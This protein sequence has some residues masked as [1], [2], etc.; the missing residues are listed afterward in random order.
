M[1]FLV[2]KKK[3]KTRQASWFSLSRKVYSRDKSSE[4]GSDPLLRDI[5]ATLI[6]WANWHDAKHAL[7]GQR[8]ILRRGQLTTSAA[9]LGDYCR[10]TRK[11]VRAR[12]D[13]LVLTERIKID[14]KPG[15][16]AILTILQFDKHQ[17]LTEK[18]PVDRAVQKT[19]FN[20]GHEKA[21]EGP[22]KGQ[23]DDF[24]LVPQV[25]DDTG[26]IIG[27]DLNSSCGQGQTKAKER[28]SQGHNEYNSTSIQPTS[29]YSAP[30]ANRTKSVLVVAEAVKTMHYQSD[31]TANGIKFKSAADAQ[32]HA[33]KNMTPESWKLLMRHFA[34]WGHFAKEFAEQYRRGYGVPYQRRLED[35]FS[36]LLDAESKSGQTEQNSQISQI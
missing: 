25:C 9:E 35:T 21:K 4:F 14:S 23:L 27:D 29:F 36:L 1:E 31:L 20:K 32:D 15:V 30:D 34:S 5:W 22:R 33:K 12:L 8:V 19:P 24:K 28:P 16:G 18:S 2:A 7:P 6:A 11:E 17:P 10:G 26:E 13:Y 3:K